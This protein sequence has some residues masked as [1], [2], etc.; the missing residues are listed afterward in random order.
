MAAAGAARAD[1][2]VVA[3]QLAAAPGETRR[4]FNQAC[5]LL[6]AAAGGESSDAAAVWLHAAE[7]RGAAVASGIGGLQSAADF[8]DEIG[9]Q[10]DTCIRIQSE[11]RQFRMFYAN[12]RQNLP[13]RQGGK[14]FGLKTELELR[15]CKLNGPSASLNQDLKRKFWLTALGCFN[16]CTPRFSNRP[17][18]SAMTQH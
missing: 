1:R 18:T 4:A 6:L 17:G 12:A 2:E 3:D 8:G 9:R 14:P 16:G 7:D 11:K 13:L 5:A 15:V 10:R